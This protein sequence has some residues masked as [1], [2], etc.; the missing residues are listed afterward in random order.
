MSELKPCPFCG[1]KR[2]YS[3]KVK[4]GIY[5]VECW[6]CGAIVESVSSTEKAIKHWNTRAIDSDELLKIAEEL[7]EEPVYDA[8]YDNTLFTEE[9]L[10]FEREI[11]KRIRKAVD[12]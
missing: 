7:E 6:C 12:E 4:K 8:Y 3:A 9:T 2:V 10:M 5:R 1:S 11:A